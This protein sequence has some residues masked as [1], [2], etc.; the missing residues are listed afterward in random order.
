MGIGG[1]KGADLLGRTPEQQ[2]TEFLNLI[3]KSWFERADVRDYMALVDPKL[4]EDYVI[5][6]RDS[7]FKLLVEFDLEPKERKDGTIYVQRIS[8]LKDLPADLRLKQKDLSKKL[9]IFFLRQFQI[10]GSIFFTIRDVQI[11]VTEEEMVKKSAPGSS[12]EKK[13]GAF[14]Q[15]PDAISLPRQTGGWRSR[16]IIS[17]SA[18]HL[19]IDGEFSFLNTVLNEP[20]TIQDT[21]PRLK[22]SDVNLYVSQP[23]LYTI[24]G[25]GNRTGTSPTIEPQILFD[26]NYFGTPTPMEGKLESTADGAGK[27]IT[28][29]LQTFKGTA[30]T[31]PLPTEVALIDPHPYSEQWT[32]RGD[33]TI[34]L[35]K[36]LEGLFLQAA[37]TNKLI[38]EDTPIAI[39][40]KLK[41]LESFT[42]RSL[43]AKLIGDSSLRDSILG[44]LN[45]AQSAANN[46]VNCVVTFKEYDVREVELRGKLKFTV[47]TSSPNQKI[48]IDVTLEQV[49]NNPIATPQ[50]ASTEVKKTSSGE[51]RDTEHN[52]GFVKAIEMVF[53]KAY[54]KQAKG[55]GVSPLALFAQLDLVK[56]SSSQNDTTIKDTSF[57]IQSPS[58]KL[59]DAN[60]QVIM[61]Q[62]VAEATAKGQEPKQIE[63]KFEPYLRVEMKGDKEFVLTVDYGAGS[64]TPYQFKDRLV[65][66]TRYRQFS[67]GSDKTAKD[68]RGRGV[69]EFL[70]AQLEEQVKEMKEAPTPAPRDPKS[71][72]EGDQEKPEF[73]E[74]IIRPT[75]DKIVEKTP[76]KAHCVARAL[77]LLNPSLL[78]GSQKD[79]KFYSNLCNMKLDYVRDGSLPEPGSSLKSSKGL[80]ILDRMIFGLVSA[81]IAADQDYQKFLRLMKYYFDHHYDQS[82]TSIESQP[83]VTKESDVI[84]HLP[85][86]CRTFEGKRVKLTPELARKIQRYTN[87]LL[88][89][90]FDHMKEANNILYMLYDVTKDKV[91]GERKVTMTQR[92]TKGGLPFLNSVAELT[93]QLLIKYYQGCEQDYRTAVT[94]LSQEHSKTPF[95]EYTG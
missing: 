37:K 16:T 70:K 2:T 55:K 59:N 34:L 88:K 24:D 36:V 46:E 11:P 84:E 47:D 61:K 60:L 75:Y 40:Y 15:P 35:P 93:R 32:K 22:V 19:F 63:V 83:L 38:S 25:A 6:T 5:V 41:L 91:T 51:Y 85:E 64:V 13:R 77:Q 9:A 69:P 82:T 43:V 49:N 17:G 27:K 58:K 87:L 53:R 20:Y 79:E 72:F 65:S 42:D 12:E 18:D 52:Y 26:Y 39:L 44:I 10:F 54:G 57:I 81:K 1:S 21:R 31:A 89:R 45:P 74:F 30:L 8:G 3:L 78:R 76:L 80:E 66:K 86:F 23:S 48:K 92:L 29:T 94:I 28:L 71:Y 90:Q 7:I 56:L 33:Q 62:S 68:D 95:V 14:L 67:I 73:K 50:S 4:Q